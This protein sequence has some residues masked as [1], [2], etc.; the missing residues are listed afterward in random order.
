[1]GFCLVLWDSVIFSF[2]YLSLRRFP[3]YSSLYVQIGAK[4]KHTFC[5]IH[6]FLAYHFHIALILSDS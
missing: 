4:A 2:P 5:R 6:K 3:V 1:M